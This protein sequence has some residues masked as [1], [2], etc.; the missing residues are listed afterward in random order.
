MPKKNRKLKWTLKDFFLGDFE[1]KTSILIKGISYSKKGGLAW[2]IGGEMETTVVSDE[3]DFEILSGLLDSEVEGKKAIRTAILA[4]GEKLTAY[5]NFKYPSLFQPEEMK[6][7]VQETFLELFK[8][9]RDGTIPQDK[10]VLALLF[11]AGL[12][13]AKDAIG[14]RKRYCNAKNNF[15]LD[16]EACVSGTKT[17]LLWNSMK[18]QNHH[19][20]LKI[21]FLRF[22]KDELKGNQKIIG[23]IV[24]SNIPNPLDYD[25][26]V[27]EVYKQ[28]GILMT[29]VQVSKTWDVIRTKYQ[30][31]LEKYARKGN[32]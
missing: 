20:D 30:E 26:I 6:D 12:C 29:K 14:I 23:S 21:D 10:P 13:N 18:S 17:G 19:L 28:T 27:A 24:G 3:I 11:Q 32:K 8:Q 4:Y 22:V 7:I 15:S 9:G 1:F 25:D 5:I 2:L 31:L 16:V